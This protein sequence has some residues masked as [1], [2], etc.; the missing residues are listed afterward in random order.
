M[1]NSL[2][3][4]PCAFSGSFSFCSQSLTAGGSSLGGNE[5]PATTIVDFIDNAMSTSRSGRCL[6]YL[7]P[8]EP[9]LLPTPVRLLHPV[10][11]FRCMHS[12]QHLCKFAV[13]R[14]VRLDL[15]D[16][17]PIPPRLK[18]YIKHGRATAANPSWRPPNTVAPWTSS[19]STCCQ[20][21][22]RT[23]TTQQPV[24]VNAAASIRASISGTALVRLKLINLIWPRSV[25][26]DLLNSRT[27][28]SAGRELW[29]YSSLLGCIE[30]M[31]CWLLLPIFAVS[32]CQ[33]VCHTA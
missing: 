31:R 32:V 6:Y 25:F 22:T 24:V 23:L 1:C 29:E 3:G 16:R 10:S 8:R 7:L 17:L 2:W 28:R 14:H 11:R 26:S 21:A 15:V 33:S 27:S 5:T 12:L 30:C 9:G 19:R 13:L 4:I 20:C 18:E